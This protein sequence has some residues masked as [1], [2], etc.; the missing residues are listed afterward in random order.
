MVLRGVIGCLGNIRQSE[1][2][3]GEILLGKKWPRRI[4]PN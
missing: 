2:K 3:R 4:F 1:V